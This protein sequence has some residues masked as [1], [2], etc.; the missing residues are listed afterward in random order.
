MNVHSSN[1]SA[2]PVAQRPQRC[3]CWLTSCWQQVFCQHYIAWHSLRICSHASM[4]WCQPAGRRSSRNSSR[5][6]I[7]SICI[8]STAMLHY[9][10]AR[11]VS[12]LT[13]L[14]QL[15]HC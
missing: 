3:H 12:N 10:H 4:Q 2:L 7:H 6:N 15:A 13:G 9:I 5:G 1:C 8:R 14:S 11:G